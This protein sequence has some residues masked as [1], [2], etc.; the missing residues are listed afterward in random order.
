MKGVKETE[1]ARQQKQFPPHDR[2][3]LKILPNCF[4]SS[5][6]SMYLRKFTFQT[7]DCCIVDA[8]KHLRIADSSNLKSGFQIVEVL[9]FGVHDF[10]DVWC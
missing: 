10:R 6:V 4:G 2:L 8:A 9:Q 7:I 1:D 3:S 5:D